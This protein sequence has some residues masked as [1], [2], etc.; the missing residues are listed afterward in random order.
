MAVAVEVIKP[1]WSNGGCD[2]SRFDRS[3]A[4]P[5]SNFMNS[6]SP[7][8]TAHVGTFMDGQSRSWIGDREIEEGGVRVPVTDL[9]LEQGLPHLVVCKATGCF[10]SVNSNGNGRNETTRTVIIE[11]KVVHRE[12]SLPQKQ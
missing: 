2:F 6:L 11:G 9:V 10:T 1:D 5:V 12:E 8:H 4:D 3:G 7:Q